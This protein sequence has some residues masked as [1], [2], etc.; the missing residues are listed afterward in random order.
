MTTAA[1]ARRPDHLSLTREDVHKL[2]SPAATD[3]EAMVFVEFCKALELN[4]FTHE[5]YLIKYDSGKPA[6]FV[7][8]VGTHLK[9]AD[10]NPNYKG[11]RSGVIVLD[12]SGDAVEKEGSFFGR[13]EQ[14]VGGWAVVSRSDWDEAQKVTVNLR[15][16]D[17][18][19]STWKKMPGTMIEK[20]ALAQALRRTYPDEVGRKYREAQAI[21]D[22]SGITVEVGEAKDYS[23]VEPIAL[24][25]E[26]SVEAD[27]VPEDESQT[28]PLLTICPTH[29][30]KWVR[31]EK[32][33]RPAWFAHKDG[34]GF[35]QQAFI[36]KTMAGELF[37][38]LDI[39]GMKKHEWVRENYNM[40]FGELRPEER[41]SLIERLRT[42]L[43][44][45]QVAQAQEAADDGVDPEP[46][47]GET[48]VGGGETDQTGMFP[49]EE[50][51]PELAAH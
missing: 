18:G 3:A 26:G 40:T 42:M 22:E 21:V 33:G 35:C 9:W 15:E 46:L 12:K 34:T 41:V 1:Q 29:A 5:A 51:S 27:A 49:A 7:I 25:D 20:I 39:A 8:G 50:V 17:T 36:L 31:F 48:D 43:P 13:N 19:K 11:Y 44:P 24:A 10:Q 32:E 6:A 4:P 14:L 30:E 45:Q 47:E 38:K 23:D 28:H 16:Y 37:E 2:I